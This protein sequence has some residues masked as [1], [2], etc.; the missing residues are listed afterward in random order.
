[1][2][3]GKV[4]LWDWDIPSNDV[5]VAPNSKEMFGYDDA[6]M[7][8]NVEEWIKIYHPDDYE[9][10]KN[11]AL[12]A[13]N[14]PAVKYYETEHRKIC[15]DGS[16]RWSMGRSYLKR[17][18]NGKVIRIIGTDTDIT[19]WKIVAEKLKDNEAFLRTILE[20]IPDGIAIIYNGEIAFCN[21]G[22][23]DIFGYDET[24]IIGTS[25]QKLISPEDVEKATQR[26]A[27][28]V[29][30]GAEFSSEYKGVR[31]GGEEIFLEVFSGNFQ[32]NGKPA[33]TSVVHD[34]TERKKAEIELQ[35]S[36]LR[37]RTLVENSPDTIFEIDYKGNILFINH[38]L[39]QYKMEDVIGSNVMTYFQIKDRK[40]FLTALK[41]VIKYKEIQTVETGPV[42][43]TFWFSRLIPI[44][45]N[46]EIDSIK[47]IATDLTEQKL[48]Q[49][50][51]RESEAKYRGLFENTSD[52]VMIAD[53]ETFQ[54]E[55]ANQATLNLFGYTQEEYLNLKIWDIS[56]EKEKTRKA[57]NRI[58]KGNEIKDATHIR[59]CLKKDGTMFSAEINPAIFIDQGRKKIIGSLRD[60]TQRLKAEAALRKSEETQRTLLKVIPDAMFRISKDG[61]YRECIP[62]QNFE[63]LIPP[64]GYIG[65][66]ISAVL[67]AEIARKE[68]NISKMP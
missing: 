65:K 68:K 41:N 59:Y 56:A 23:C 33:L 50:K 27:E 54:F 45:R 19:E 42:D 46:G 63:T 13:F 53:A 9:R 44:F 67:P 39:P 5:F 22:F 49:Q 2:N 30:G 55:A 31:K 15:K 52:A 25:P 7:S 32:Y 12:R 64:D 8:N 38:I 6:S 60:I 35:N 14:D 11:I 37:Y 17:D 66:T 1:M 18:K 34:I 48:A 29:S 3:A 24:E 57:I 40:K 28:I 4:G 20:K 51:M 61:V 36:E 21:Q 62:A 58:K 26:I 16:I 47:V 43:N 10:D